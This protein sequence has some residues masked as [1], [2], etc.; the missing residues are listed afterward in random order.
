LLSY[1]DDFKLLG[2]VFLGLLPLLL[3]VKPG[4]GG[5]TGMAH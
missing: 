4:K 2:L 1:L 5:V 3:L